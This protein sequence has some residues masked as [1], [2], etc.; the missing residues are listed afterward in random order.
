[1][2]ITQAYYNGVSY[3][4][5]PETYRRRMGSQ[6]ADFKAAIIELSLQENAQKSLSAILADFKAGLEHYWDIPD[7]ETLAALQNDYIKEN[8]PSMLTT[9]REI[10]FLQQMNA[11]QRSMA[12]EATLFIERIVTVEET[13]EYSTQQG[14][15]EPKE[16]IDEQPKIISGTK[17]LADYLGCCPSTAFKI[18]SSRVLVKDAIQYKVGENWKFNREKLDKYIKKNPELLPRKRT[19]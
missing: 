15:E 5:G 12:Q 11:V 9:I 4:E 18:I 2:D 6:F 10:K 16:K 14:I 19:K 8:V 7:E 13:K 17:G 3:E 1:M